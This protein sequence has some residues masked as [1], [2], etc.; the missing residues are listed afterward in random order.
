[1]I[2]QQSGEL[3]KTNKNSYVEEYTDGTPCA[4]GGHPRR[5][6]V[7]YYCDEFAGFDDSLPNDQYMRDF[8]FV[9]LQEVDWCVY[10]AK[11]ATRFMC[12]AGPAGV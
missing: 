10:H 9:E 3:L 6:K 11:V 1:V 12:G 7:Q 5:I 8:L 2:Y 4:V